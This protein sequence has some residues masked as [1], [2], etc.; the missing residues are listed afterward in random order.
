MVSD[1]TDSTK[2]TKMLNTSQTCGQITGYAFLLLKEQ[3]CMLTV[4]VPLVLSVNAR[5]FAPPTIY[6]I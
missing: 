1:H 6:D 4:Q 5:T 3:P 2:S